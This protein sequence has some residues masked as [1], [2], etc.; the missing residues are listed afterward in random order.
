MFTASHLR[1]P[2]RDRS[3]LV[4]VLVAMAAT[5]WALLLA[6]DA[7]P[8][9]RYLHHDTPSGLGSP[10]ELSLFVVGWT[11][12]IVAMMLPTA[13]PLVV[14]FGALVRRRRRSWALVGLVV[15]GY[16]AVWSLFGSIAWIGDRG[17]HAAV[18]AV[19]FLT[20]YPQ[21]IL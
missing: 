19:P 11:V 5:A 17:I 16:L 4:V 8:Y 10:L 1:A 12:M 20:T 14:T 2:A 21:I 9:G 7:T 18:D 15:V 3:I 13:I 6:W